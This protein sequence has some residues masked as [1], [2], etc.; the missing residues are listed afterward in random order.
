MAQPPRESKRK[1]QHALRSL[2]RGEA[3]AFRSWI[4]N[5]VYI[6]RSLSCKDRTYVGY[7]SWQ[8][9]DRLH[10]HNKGEVPHTSKYT[11]WSIEFYACFNDKLTAL[12]FEQYLKSH[13]GKAFSNKRLLTG[14]SKKIRS[15]PNN[16]NI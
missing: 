10:K 9:K 8:G 12:A 5:F 2:F 13:S 6:L 3:R 14:V 16:P 15:K 11:P 7:T 1:A 4:I